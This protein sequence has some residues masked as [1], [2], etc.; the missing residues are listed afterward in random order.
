MSENL[1]AIVVGG[2]GGLGSA[3][4]RRLAA[5]GYRVTIA[6]LDIDRANS[7][8]LSLGGSG[9]QAIQM[10]VLNDESVDAA[11]DAIEARSPA[12]VL[13]VASGGPLT[14]VSRALSITNMATA[15]WNKSLTYNLNGVFFCV[16]KFGQLREANPIE[17]G[18]IIVIGSGAGQSAGVSLEIGYTASKAG[19]I[20]LVRQAAFDLAA[21]GL[22]VN[23]IAPGP[24]ATEVMLR[25]TTEEIRA[26]LAAPSVLKR[27]GKPEEVGA[28]VA[29]LASPEAA[30]I[31]GTTL[32]V[33]GG[34]HMH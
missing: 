3:T 25:H 26:V 1:H 31:T 2:A 20:G 28:A 7:V 16:R 18:R 22:T 9:H 14:G 5:D 24:I 29:F 30:Y 8:L 19:V 17:H 23:T 33:N 32:D 15:D 12:R 10:D 27:L 21:A 4:A 13:V 11:F 34:I 6:D